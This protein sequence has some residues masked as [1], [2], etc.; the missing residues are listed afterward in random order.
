MQK[1]AILGVWDTNKCEKS[2]VTMLN[3][4]LLLAKWIIHRCKI[5]KQEPTL[6]EF[7]VE[8]RLRLDVEKYI[9]LSKG[10]KVKFMKRFQLLDDSI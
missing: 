1:D 3:Y 9:C 4:C 2:K 10:E 8:L 6:Y 5:R 7:L